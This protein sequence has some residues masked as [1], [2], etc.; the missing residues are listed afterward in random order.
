MIRILKKKEDKIRFKEKFCFF[1]KKKIKKKLIWFHGASVG[2][3]SSIIPIILKL[4]KNNEIDQILVT[5]STLSSSNIFNQFKFKKTVHQY[6][7]IDTNILS[8]N[9]L[10][11]WKPSLAIFIDSEIWPNMILNLKEKSIPILLLNARITEK[12]FRRWKILKKF[13]RKIFQ[14]IDKSLVSN[15][16]TAKYLRYFGVKNIKSIGNLKFVQNKHKDLSLPKNLI[17]FLSKKIAW[18]SSSTHSGEELISL[19]VH[20]ILKKKYKNIISIIIP[21]HIDR[22]SD[23]VKM[24]NEHNLKVHSHS[25][26][27]KIPEKIDI[28]LVDAYG[29]TEKFFNLIKIVFVGGSLVK[30]GGQNP[31][32]PARHGCNVLHGPNI[33]NFKNI[34]NYLHKIKVSKKIQGHKSLYKNIEKLVRNKS[35]VKSVIKRMKKLGDKI[36][37]LTIK[38]I[39]NTLL[40]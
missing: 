24:F 2:E 7:P 25:W 35:N 20:K 12:S 10:D 34:Y 29:E 31:L 30:H 15:P 11:Y 14:C 8:K 4:E 3:I 9:F 6:F 38:E 18:C 5:S 33:D 1:S 22:S 37:I 13:S 39:G 26:K 17:K 32:E 28:Y 19:K 40:K 21:R 27:S 23:L 36:L 16:E